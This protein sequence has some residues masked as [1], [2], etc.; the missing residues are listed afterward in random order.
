M[1]DTAKKV[2]RVVAA[3]RESRR[4]QRS[5]K[6]HHVQ[7]V[8]DRRNTCLGYRDDVRVVSP[9]LFEVGKKEG[10]VSSYRSAQRPSILRLRQRVSARRNRISSIQPLV[11]KKPIDP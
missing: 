6:A 8:V 11:S 7:T 1:I 5:S 10:S 4:D 2:R 3:G 9:R